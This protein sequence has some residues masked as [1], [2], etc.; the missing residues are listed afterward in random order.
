MDW[1]AS[2]TNAINYIENN[3][4][5]SEL[6]PIS[7]AS[8]VNFSESHF[9]KA[10][11]VLTG[12]SVAE[13]IRNRRLF[14][15]GEELQSTNK[16]VLDVALE[17]C[18]ETPEAFCKAFKRFHGIPPSNSKNATLKEFYKLEIQ[19]K[20]LQNKPLQFEIM[21]KPSFY[22][23]GD[24]EIVSD[25]DAT[26]LW[27]KC[28]ENKYVAKCYSEQ[29]FE[30]IVGVFE[31]GGYTIKAKCNTDNYKSAKHIQLQKWAVFQCCG[32]MPQAVDETWSKIYSIWMNTNMGLVSAKIPQLE[33]YYLD[34]EEY[35]CEIWIP[36]V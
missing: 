25:E 34:D 5:N 32:E 35:N 30:Q 2:I 31:N 28:L 21:E 14:L 13:Y 15:A 23:I 17:F 3:I 11:L 6:S 1:I 26:L 22:L 8:E 27:E 33:V 19:L 10:F 36:I 16:A 20:L 24:A 18:Y 9:S 4:K 7:V 29:G 12:F